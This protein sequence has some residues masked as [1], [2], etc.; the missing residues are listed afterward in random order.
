MVCGT[1][2]VI[3]TCV[4]PVGVPSIRTFRVRFIT[5]A[6]HA[7]FTIGCSR[8]VPESRVTVLPATAVMVR[9]SKPF[10]D[11]VPTLGCSVGAIEISSPGSQPDGTSSSVI[12][13]APG[14]TVASARVHEVFADPTASSFP[15][16]TTQ[17]PVSPST[18]TSPPPWKLRSSIPTKR[19]VCPYAEEAGRIVSVPWTTTLRELSS[20]IESSGANANAAPALMVTPRTAAVGASSVTIWPAATVT[21]SVGPGDSPLLQAAGFD[22]FPESTLVTGRGSTVTVMDAVALLPA[23]SRAVA[24]NV[25]VPTPIGPVTVSYTH[26]RAHE[27]D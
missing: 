9:R 20:V 23:R 17:S 13:V 2:A 18:T 21:M 10:H 16:S 7:P 1:C 6:P 4:R 12:E 8:D 14:A 19:S 11:A 5:A 3:I 22:Q 26:L 25:C 24:E 15:A 27:T